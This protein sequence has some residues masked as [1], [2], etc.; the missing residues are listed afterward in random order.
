MAL[1]KTK[2]IK[3]RA[4]NISQQCKLS[5]KILLLEQH[6]MPYHA[7]PAHPPPHK[8]V[9]PINYKLYSFNSFQFHFCETL[10]DEHNY[11][12]L[13]L[14]FL[15]KEKMFPLRFHDASMTPFR[16]F[17]KEKQYCKWLWIFIVFFSTPK[18]TISRT[19]K[20][21]VKLGSRSE[22]Y[23][24]YCYL[25]TRSLTQFDDNCGFTSYRRQ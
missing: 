14:H 2:D 22:S 4:R 18:Q 25:L 9:L 19:R 24:H 10:N 5:W 23:C 3:K 12:W 8:H 21:R 13:R 17:C 1:L 15:F 16:Y 7:Q 20:H 6:S 11:V